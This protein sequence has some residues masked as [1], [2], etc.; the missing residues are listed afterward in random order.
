MALDNVWAAWFWILVAATAQAQ[1]LATIEVKPAASSRLESRRMRVLPNGN[2]AATSINAPHSS[3]SHMTF[4]R[5]HQSVCPTSR[6]G[7][8]PEVRHHSESSGK[9]D[10][11]SSEAISGKRVKD[12]FR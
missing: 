4:R 10:I 8:H 1:S 3:T 12:E 6:M 2:L 7:L 5:T 11:S 9:T